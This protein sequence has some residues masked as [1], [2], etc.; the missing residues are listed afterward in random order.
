MVRRINLARPRAAVAW[1]AVFGALAGLLAATY[2]SVAGEPA[3]DDAIA[4]EE[5]MAAATDGHGH[6]HDDEQVSRDTQ[7]GVGLFSGYALLGAALG[8]GLAVTALSLRGDGLAPFTRFLTAGGI[9]A[10]AVTVVPWFKYPPNPPA[11]GDESTV[12]ART[13]TSLALTALAVVVL[14]GVAHLSSRL[15]KAGWDGP[16]RMATVAVA[17]VVGLGV[18]MT[19]MPANSTTIPEEMPASLIWR[20]RTASLLGNLLLWGALTL[21]A[22]MAYHHSVTRDAHDPAVPFDRVTSP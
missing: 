1:T 15:R 19:A 7:R 20:F 14:A 2:F 8:L 10:L 3:I 18:L 21:L 16:R 17:A 12:G 13:F 5:E 11:V 4:I 22:A 9:L 6:D